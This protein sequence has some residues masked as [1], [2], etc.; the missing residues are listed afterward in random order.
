MAEGG[1]LR[2][3]VSEIETVHSKTRVA[4]TDTSDAHFYFQYAE[5]AVNWNADCL[6]GRIPRCWLNVRLLP[7][8]PMSNHRLDSV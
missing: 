5:S 7:V 3:P 8:S 1:E 4:V 2:A 6:T